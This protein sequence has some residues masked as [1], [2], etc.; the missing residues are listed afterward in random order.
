[1]RKCILCD[2]GADI[3]LYG[4]GEKNTLK[5]CQELESGKNIKDIRDIPQTVYLCRPEHIPGGITDQD[6][7]LHSHEECLRDKR[8]QA[9]NFRH[10]E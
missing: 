9:E 2:S 8:A 5:L 1:M 6:I 4:M 7:V 10:I 3:I